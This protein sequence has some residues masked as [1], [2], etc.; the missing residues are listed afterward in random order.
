MVLAPHRENQHVQASIDQ[1]VSL[2]ANLAIGAAL[3]G[4]HR[5]RV[6]IHPFCVR[7][8]DTVFVPV[9]LVLVRVELD[10]HD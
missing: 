1:T 10:F 5:C 3:I 6:E 8:R 9:A 7:Q 4:N 2:P